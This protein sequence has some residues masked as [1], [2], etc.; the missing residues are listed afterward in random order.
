MSNPYSASDAAF[1]DTVSGA[2]TY[3]PKML[4]MNGR[5][6]RL[7][8]L[9]YS[10]GLGLLLGAVLVALTFLTGGSPAALI[11][12]Q[13]L[14]VIGSLAVT[15]IVG[16]RRLHDLG[17]SGWPTIGLLIPLVNLFVALW[18]VFTPGKPDANE[19]GPP[20]GPNTTGIKVAALVL[21]V[22][23]ILG[24]IAAVSMPAYQNYVQRAQQADQQSL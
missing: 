13:V 6:G 1:T 3:E 7:R 23:A 14:Y 20:P 2:A 16:R 19:Y 8:Y 9:A 11:A 18:I 5:I 10:V 4:Q 15:V 17:H 21:P 22:I 24:V 12:V